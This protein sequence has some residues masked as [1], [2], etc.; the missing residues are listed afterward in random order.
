LGFLRSTLRSVKLVGYFVIYGV[1]LLVKRPETR[2]ARAEWLHRFCAAALHGL[3]IELTVAGEFP[4]RGAVIA[5]HLSYV[6]VIVFAALQPCV[7]VSKA[8]IRDWPVLGWMT[9]MAGTVYVERGHGGSAL[10]AKGGMTAAAE[11]GLPV[12]FFPEGTTSNG[13]ELLPFHS[14]LL[15]QAM[16]VEEPVTAAYIRYALNEENEADVTV[17]DDVCFWGDTPMLPHIFR[18]LGLRGVHVTV[19]FA[20]GPIRFSSDMLHRK[21]AAIEARAAV[22]AMSTLNCEVPVSMQVGADLL[23][24]PV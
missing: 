20:D 24:R 15:A 19:R 7:F 23:D 5:N 14:G 12:V 18:F 13:R 1:E 10:K 2:R 9:S 22:C 21:R 16:A 8:E 4:P 17:E 11:A 3:G 6:D